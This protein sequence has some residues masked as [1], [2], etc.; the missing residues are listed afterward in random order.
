[1]Y[2]FSA[3]NGVIDNMKVNEQIEQEK[4]TLFCSNVG[5]TGVAE[6]VLSINPVSQQID[7]TMYYN[8]E[9]VAQS[10]DPALTADEKKHLQSQIERLTAIARI[11]YDV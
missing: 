7:L 10:V 11:K 6:I 2:R 4:Y 1:M 5:K 9:I 3:T 8:D